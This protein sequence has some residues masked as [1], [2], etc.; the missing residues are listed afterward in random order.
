MSFQGRH[1]TPNHG[2]ICCCQWPLC[3]TGGFRWKMVRLHHGSYFSTVMFVYARERKRDSFF[4]S[5]NCLEWS[6]TCKGYGK[7]YK[8]WFRERDSSLEICFVKGVWM[9]CM[10]WRVKGRLQWKWKQTPNSSLAASC[11]PFQVPLLFSSWQSYCCIHDFHR[12][13]ESFK[14]KG[15][16]N[17]RRLLLLLLLSLCSELLSRGFSF[18]S[19]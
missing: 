5:R 8:R 3:R 10:S 7:H 4:F 15:V 13:L 1:H 18:F 6:N 14:V 19:Q 12:A 2:G 11:A 17:E 9:G 16:K